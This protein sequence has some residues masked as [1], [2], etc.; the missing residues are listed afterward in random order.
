MDLNFCTHVLHVCPSRDRTSGGRFLF[1]PNIFGSTLYVRIRAYM[2]RRRVPNNKPVWELRTWSLR[3]LYFCFPLEKSTRNL[4][5]HNIFTSIRDRH[6]NINFWRTSMATEQ[7]GVHSRKKIILRI[8]LY[9]K[10]TGII[11]MVCEHRQSSPCWRRT[12]R[13]R[14]ALSR[15]EFNWSGK[16]YEYEM[17]YLRPA[18][19]VNETATI[20]R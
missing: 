15:S 12:S 3:L 7:V 20:H 1:S 13:R 10:Y 19:A 11:D 14:P 16:R 9:S 2:S 5:G 6:K 17:N 4:V 18:P 8:Q